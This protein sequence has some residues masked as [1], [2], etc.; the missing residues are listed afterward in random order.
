MIHYMLTPK[1]GFAILTPGYLWQVMLMQT[2]Y[3]MS[4]MPWP[5]FIIRRMG[6]D[7]I[8]MMDG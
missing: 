3:G 6:T 2:V 4:V 8:T 5:S 7:G 1:T